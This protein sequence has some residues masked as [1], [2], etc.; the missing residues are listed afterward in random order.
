MDAV[1]R[2]LEK[3]AADDHLNEFSEALQKES[4]K[5]AM[6]RQ[7]GAA[8]DAALMRELGI[9]G[10]GRVTKAAAAPVK[11]KQPPQRN[12]H[13]EGVDELDAILDELK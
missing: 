2:D 12:V 10:D 7:T 13:E 1:A 11:K 5:P 3:Q 4:L 9:V 8:S 6:V